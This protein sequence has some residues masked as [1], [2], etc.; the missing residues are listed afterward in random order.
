M[1]PRMYG[2]RLEVSPPLHTFLEMGRE[3]DSGP[4]FEKGYPSYDAV[5]NTNLDKAM[6]APIEDKLR[7]AGM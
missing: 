3:L 5:N 4:V 6:K 7:K 2:A 1:P